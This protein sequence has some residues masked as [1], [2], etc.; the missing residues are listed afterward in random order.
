MKT[1]K[2]TTIT[3]QQ[4]KP[5]NASNSNPLS[6]FLFKHRVQKGDE[7]RPITNTRIGNQEL[8]IYGGKYSIPDDKYADFLTNQ[9]YRE[10]FQK[11][12]PEYLTETQLEKGPLLVDIDLRHPYDITTRQYT[13]EHITDLVGEYLATFKE[14]FQIDDEAVIHTYL[15]QKPTV[16]RVANDKITKD[17]AHLIFS[18]HLDHIAQQLIR[19]KILEKIPETWQTELNIT[20][21]WDKVFDEGISKGTTNWQL[22]GSR[23]PGNESY[24]LTGIF[25][26]TFDSMEEEFTTDFADASTFNMAT[27]I[28]KLSARYPHHYEPFMTPAFLAEHTQLKENLSK[29]AERQ[30]TQQPLTN[31]MILQEIDPLSI[32]NHEEL[33]EALKQFLDSIPPDRYNEYEAYSYAMTLPNTYYGPGSYD[34]WFQVGCALKN[35]SKSLFI[36]WLAFSAQSAMFSFVSDVPNLWDQWLKFDTKTNGL[37]LRS[38]MYWSKKDALNKYKEVKSSSIDYYIEQTLDNGLSDFAVSDKKQMVSDWDLAKV[39]YHMKK[40][41]YLCSSV[42][43]NLW[44]RYKDHRWREIDSGTSLRTAIS[45]ELRALYAKKAEQLASSKSALE[46]DDPK[47][48]YLQARMEKCLEIHGKLGRTADKK[49]IMTEVRDMFYDE[50]FDRKIDTNPHL[51]CVGNGIWD[52]KERKFR[53]GK[54]ED[55]ISMSTRIDYEPLSDK[56]DTIV[57]EIKDFF[58]KIFPVEELREYMWD[59]LASTL[60]GTA[61]NQTF[62]NY[63]GG[64]RNGKSVVTSLMTK[65]LGDYKG[66]LP[67]TAVTTKRT[68]VGGLAPEIAG[69]KGKRYVVMQE[70]T[71]KD[72][73]N[74][75][76]LKE[77]TSG[78]D[79]IQ[80]R[81]LF[82]MPVSFLPQFKLVVCANILPEIRAQDHGTW[83]RIRVV[84]FMSLFTE[85]PVEGD[86]YKPYQYKL[87]ASIDE[88]FDSWKKVMLALLV[89]RVLK[90]NGRVLD[91]ETVLKASNE[92]KQKQDVISQFID[93]RIERAPGQWLSQT[94]ANQGFKLWHEENFGSR[95][96]QP[97]ELHTALDRQFGEHIKKKGW[98]DI[99]LVFD[100]D[101]HTNEV[102]SDDASF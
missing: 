101:T 83:R 15:F 36:I 1:L 30:R 59:H 99:R 79:A 68:A 9:Y 16:N 96:P 66:E 45:T 72:V 88:K 21:S 92:Y 3:H 90:T 27:D 26:S 20:N 31:R 51:L 53:E 64:G 71:Q 87:D 32:S 89:D 67:L 11:Q 78:H 85:N 4:I 29:P 98:R 73:L 54:P 18:L 24:R 33:A 14:S 76:I 56:H 91:C 46:D 58:K 70:P 77:L 28:F 35:I 22:V 2:K 74:E 12:Q 23:K 50:E 25:T 41:Q 57:E 17:G 43:G 40:D 8:E 44:Y 52:F 80:A 95:G 49:N 19:T 69:L 39:L 61:L 94:D 38:I 60:V 13:L 55:Y 84:P 62:N 65:V 93:D 100:M 7:S 97:K 5:P 102:D 34:K 6:D 47:Y 75:G 86:P 10:V 63:L 48:K 81:S 37:T 82:S 42:K